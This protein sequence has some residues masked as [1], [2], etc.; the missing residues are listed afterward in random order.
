MKRT[1]KPEATTGGARLSE[2][3]AVYMPPELKTLLGQAADERSVP[4]SELVVKICADHFKR[5]DLGV[6]P[7]KRPGRPRKQPA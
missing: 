6:V 7:R 2:I 1:L 4:M 5:P 3:L